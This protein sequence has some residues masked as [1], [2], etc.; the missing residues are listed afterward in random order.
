MTILMLRLPGDPSPGPSARRSK[1]K[2]QTEREREREQRRDRVTATQPCAV[3]LFRDIQSGDDVETARRHDTIL[4]HGGRCARTAY[5][6]IYVY[7]HTQY[8]QLRSVE[9]AAIEGSGRTTGAA[10]PIAT[11]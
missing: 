3:V 8:L 5:V 2:R 7:V 6:Y 9:G 10:R 11:N 4:P 1:G